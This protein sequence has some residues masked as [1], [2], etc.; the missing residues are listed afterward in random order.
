MDLNGKQP[1]GIGRMDRTICSAGY[2]SSAAEA[3]LV[4]ALGR[5]NLTVV[6]GQ[7]VEKVEIEHGCAVG[8]RL[9]GPAAGGGGECRVVRAAEVILSAG[10]IKTPQILMLSG[11]SD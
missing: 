4:P 10:S 1:W 11:I 2:R 9:S 7:L 5:S 8:V 6:T 3:H